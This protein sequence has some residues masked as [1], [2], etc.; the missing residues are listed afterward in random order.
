MGLTELILSSLVAFRPFHS[1]HH[2]FVSYCFPPCK[3]HRETAAVVCARVWRIIS[4][5]SQRKNSRK[6]SAYANPYTCPTCGMI[7]FPTLFPGKGWRRRSRK[8]LVTKILKVLTKHVRVQRV[9][10]GIWKQTQFAATMYI[11]E[12][13]MTVS[14]LFFERNRFFFHWT[15]SASSVKCLW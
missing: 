1:I 8:L 3:I 14:Y 12:I 4:L 11:R 13:L 5:V 10:N 9:S 7:Q 6:N 2:I 15:I